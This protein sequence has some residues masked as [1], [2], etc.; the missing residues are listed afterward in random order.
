[1]GMAWSQGEENSP[2]ADP[3]EEIGHVTGRSRHTFRVVFSNE[4]VVDLVHNVK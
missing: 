2:C 3:I 1:M 4:D